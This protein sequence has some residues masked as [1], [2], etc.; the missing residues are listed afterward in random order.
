[1]YSSWINGNRCYDIYTVNIS[2]PITIGNVKNGGI[3]L[4]T[5]L[6]TVMP[7]MLKIALVGIEYWLLK[8]GVKV[9][10]LLIGTMAVGVLLFAIGAIA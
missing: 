10:P 8:K 5:T 2:T 6:D 4:Q 7:G 9:V 3:V 1:M